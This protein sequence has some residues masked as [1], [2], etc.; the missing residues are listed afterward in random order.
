M[1]RRVGLGAPGRH[2]YPGSLA[3]PCEDWR[4]A[5]WSASPVKR[6]PSPDS[7]LMDRYRELLDD[8]R[9]D[10]DLRMILGA[11]GGAADPD[12]LQLALPLCANAGVRAEAEVAVK[13]IAAV[14]QSPASASC[15]G[16]PG[17]NPGEAL[18]CMLDTEPV[19]SS[20]RSERCT[21][22]RLERP[23]LLKARQLCL[24]SGQPEVRIRVTAWRLV[25][26]VLNQRRI[27][28][29]W[30]RKPPV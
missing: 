5:A 28:A 1:A 14:H 7:K 8:A 23:V 2:L 20:P 29:I 22:L 19:S 21:G 9:G 4:C 10:A 12:A 18:S 27:T 30:R 25:L 11:L 17:A 3:K 16:G 15:P 6:T 13:K 24:V 26:N